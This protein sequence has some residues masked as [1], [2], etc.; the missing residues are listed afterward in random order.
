MIRTRLLVLLATAFIAGCAHQ[1]VV[2]PESPS[3]KLRFISKSFGSTFL[4]HTGQEN[5]FF[6]AGTKQDLFDIKEKSNVKMIGTSEEELSGVRERLI[7]ASTPFS[8][9]IQY[10]RHGGIVRIQCTVKSSFLP[11]K[12]AQ[13]ELIFDISQSK[14]SVTLYKL[15]TLVDGTISR[16]PIPLGVR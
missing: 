1:Y 9:E 15:G 5:K 10:E 11:E 8:F 6:V 16:A 7:E 12:E 4:Y 14:C 13:Y 2:K 3:A